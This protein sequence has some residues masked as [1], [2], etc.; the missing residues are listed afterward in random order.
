MQ[1]VKYY[2]PDVIDAV[3]LITLYIIFQRQQR[4]DQDFSWRVSINADSYE[5]NSV[6]VVAVV[7][8]LI[9]RH[10]AMLA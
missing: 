7:G 6:S 3:N 9:A 5:Q 8:Q 4:R 1:N 2:A 10:N